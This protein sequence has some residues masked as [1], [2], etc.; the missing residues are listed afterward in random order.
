MKRQV[1]KKNSFQASHQVGACDP[2]R[3]AVEPL[4]A[5]VEAQPVGRLR[6]LVLDVD[7]ARAARIVG[8]H[9]LEVAERPRAPSSIS[10]RARDG[11]ICRAESRRAR[12]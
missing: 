9:R 12:A 10:C 6:A 3:P 8:L 7:R 1:S 4:D 11:G 2:D 5:G